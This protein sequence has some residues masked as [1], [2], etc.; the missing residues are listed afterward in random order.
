MVVHRDKDNNKNGRAVKKK[1]K[2]FRTPLKQNN[3]QYI[4]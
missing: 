1:K 3:F 2:K 4:K